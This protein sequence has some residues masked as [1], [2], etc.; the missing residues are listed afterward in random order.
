MGFSDSALVMCFVFHLKA[1]RYFQKHNF[2]NHSMHP[3]KSC[4]WSD[5]EHCRA[6]PLLAGD[7][8]RR[9]RSIFL[10][11]CSGYQGK[12]FAKSH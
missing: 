12:H 8:P 1:Y 3:Y 10:C 11:F 9:Y 2:M 6:A 7:A 5:P 4:G